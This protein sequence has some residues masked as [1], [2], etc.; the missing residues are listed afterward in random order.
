MAAIGVARPG[1]Q[2]MLAR[3]GA[4]LVVTTLDDVCL[5]NLLEGRLREQPATEEIRSR[6]TQRPPSAWT[7]VYDGFDP[8][9]QGL[10]EALCAVGNGYFVTR[11]ALPESQADGVNYPGTYVA[12]L[13]NRAISKVAG[14]EVENE[15]LVNV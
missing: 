11:G 8:N 1:D 14:R 2:E 15:D 12:G 9:R 5:S 13:Y 10:R 6:H 7:L 3:A 4:D